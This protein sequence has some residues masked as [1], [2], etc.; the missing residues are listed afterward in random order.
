[1]HIRCGILSGDSSR[2]FTWYTQNKIFEID[3]WVLDFLRLEMLA[4][5]PG[6]LPLGAS[7]KRNTEAF[8]PFSRCSELLV[9]TGNN[10]TD[11]FFARHHFAILH[12]KEG[13]SRCRLH[14]LQE[15]YRKCQQ[16][17]HTNATG[18]SIRWLSTMLTITLSRTPV[19]VGWKC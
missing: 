6:N 7:D 9:A 1:M 18:S 8:H 5:A 19:I 17:G 16:N 11:V 12:H 2:S 10:R 15:I 3:F 14:R 13:F 4:D